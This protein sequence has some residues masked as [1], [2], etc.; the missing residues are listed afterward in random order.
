MSTTRL[1]GDLKKIEWDKTQ[2][3]IIFCLANISTTLKAKDTVGFVLQEWL[4]DFMLQVGYQFEEPKN[5]QSF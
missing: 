2:G 4:K 3:K 1:Y 5:S